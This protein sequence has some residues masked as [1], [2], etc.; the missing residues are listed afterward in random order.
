MSM[1]LNDWPGSSPRMRGTPYRRSSVCLLH[2]IIPAYAGNT[3][4]SCFLDLRFWDHPR[5]CGEHCA[6]AFTMFS[7][8]GSSPRMRGTPFSGSLL[9]AWLGIIPAYA[10]NTAIFH[11][12]PSYIW[13]HPRVCGE[14]HDCTR[15]ACPSV[16][17]SPRMRGTRERH[18][19]RFSRRGIIP[20]YAGNTLTSVR[21]S[22][23]SGDHPR[24]C[25]EHL[26]VKNGK[27]HS[28][29]SSPRMR[30]TRRLA[31][32][33]QR[34]VGIIPAYAGN[35]VRPHVARK[36]AWDHPRVCGEHT[37]WCQSCF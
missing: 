30:G 11:E 2:G 14:H 16:G 24:V 35:T 9:I 22:L 36:R 5:V 17:S 20:A 33:Q 18:D 15:R 25:G 8:S 37:R 34:M 19:R 21:K 6:T 3:P 7:V 29:G 12:F 4:V 31:R 23:E 10:G 13:D 27:S 26:G 32:H 28:K 1:M